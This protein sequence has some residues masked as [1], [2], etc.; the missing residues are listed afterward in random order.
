[1]DIKEIEKELK[2]PFKI[3]EIEWR[4]TAKSKDETKGLVVAYITNRAIQ[5]RLDEIFGITGWKN[6]YIICD[7]SKICGLSLL[8]NGEWITKYDGAS[9]TNIESTKG[10]LSNSMK[11]AAVQWGI[12]RYLYKLPSQWVKIKHLGGKNFALDE[13]PK[14]PSWAIPNAKDDNNWDKPKKEIP[15]LNDDIQKCID[16]FNKI[17]IPK[18]QLETYL[19]LE[20]DTFTKEDIGT[21]RNIYSQIVNNKKKKED[22]FEYPEMKQPTQKSKQ[23]NMFLEGDN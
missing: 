13:I 3:D 18:A 4:I 1:M 10:G 14:L 8:I 16:A 9:D 2:K 20:A 6:E 23:L 19:Q 17:G 22:F 12:G 21:L 5:N 11:R 7:K 15:E